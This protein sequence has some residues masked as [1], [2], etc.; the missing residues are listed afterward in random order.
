LEVCIIEDRGGGLSYEDFSETVGLYL[1]NVPGCE[2]L[3]QKEFE[4][5]VRECWKYYGQSS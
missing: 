3:G 5:I 4:K 1:G 2:S